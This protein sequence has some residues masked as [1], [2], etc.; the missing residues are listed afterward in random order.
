M[1][2][3]ENESLIG[4][5]KKELVKL[6]MRNILGVVTYHRYYYI[7]ELLIDFIVSVSKKDIKI[8]LDKMK[9]NCFCM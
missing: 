1:E 3:H 6:Q 4:K 5:E 7:I 9:K 8:N 2:K